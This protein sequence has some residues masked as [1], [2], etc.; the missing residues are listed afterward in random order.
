MRFMFHSNNQVI[1]VC[2]VI[3]IVSENK[4]WLTQDSTQKQTEAAAFE[5]A[6]FLCVRKAELHITTLL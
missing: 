1:S 6:R 3:V 5:S 2:C 4:Q